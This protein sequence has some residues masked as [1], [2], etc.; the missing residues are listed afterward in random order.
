MV[1]QCTS[2]VIFCGISKYVHDELRVSLKLWW[3]TVI[4]TESPQKIQG[5][6]SQP[7]GW[8]QGPLLLPRSPAGTDPGSGTIFGLTTPMFQ[9]DLIFKHISFPKIIET[10]QRIWPAP[11]R[12]LK[13]SET[14][15]ANELER[16][17]PVDIWGFPETTVPLNHPSIDGFYTI[18]HPAMGYP[19]SWKPR[20]CLVELM[21]LRLVTQG[22]SW[23]SL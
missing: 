22:Q 8:W 9:M 11:N 21:T 20:Y 3:H 15:R 12:Q 10:R 18:N 2:W 23:F 1:E 6:P 19:H 7:V 17:D 5:C 4:V 16:R 13:I 14:F